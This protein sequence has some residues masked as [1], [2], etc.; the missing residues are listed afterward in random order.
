MPRK[1]CLIPSDLPF[2]HKLQADGKGFRK[3]HDFGR[4]GGEPESG[5]I[6]SNGKLWG[7]TARGGKHNEGTIYSLSPGSHEVKHIHDLVYPV[8]GELFQSN[9]KLWGMIAL[10]GANNCG[11]VFNINPKDAT[12]RE[13]HDFDCKGGRFPEGNL[14]ESN[15]QLWGLTRFGGASNK[16]VL[17]SLT[18]KDHHFTKVLDFD[19]TTGGVPYSTLVEVPEQD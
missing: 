19:E 15:R 4:K 10:R 13:V 9:G 7:T 3:I 6:F 2:N 8:L 14:M 16:G 18:E 11:I 12:Y 5:L 1:V 17:F